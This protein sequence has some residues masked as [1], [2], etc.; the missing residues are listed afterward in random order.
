MSPSLLTVAILPPRILPCTLRDA[1]HIE[2]CPHCYN[3]GGPESV[4]Q[5]AI[6]KTDPA[7]LSE[8]GGGRFPLLIALEMGEVAANGNYLERDQLAVRHGICGDPE[9]VRELD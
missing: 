7:V 8:Y 5:R 1:L 3:S 4:N 9:Q 6:D 2:Y